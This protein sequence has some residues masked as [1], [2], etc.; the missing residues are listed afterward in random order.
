MHNHLEE[1]INLGDEDEELVHTPGSNHVKVEHSCDSAVEGTA[2]LESL[3][4][5]VEGEHEKEDSDGLIV[6]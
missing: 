1:N 6:I 5:Q 2:N 3:N 4:P